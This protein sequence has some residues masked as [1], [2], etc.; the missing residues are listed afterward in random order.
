MKITFRATFSHPVH[1]LA[2]NL[3]GVT[4]SCPTR[5]EVYCA[6][7]TNGMGGHRW[8]VREANTDKRHQIPEAGEYPSAEAAKAGVSALFE[9][10]ID[11]WQMFNK[12][13]GMPISAEDL[14]YIAENGY[15]EPRPTLHL[16]AANEPDLSER[17]AKA[18]CG[19]RVLQTN[20]VRQN[21]TCVQCQ[22]CEERQAKGPRLVARA[23]K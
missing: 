5:I 9:R 23:N 15:A 14:R 4:V 13:T 8:N 17:T 1:G 7:S 12:C 6:S 19:K 10:Q 2:L 21:P 22:I 3:M 16:A 18:Q 20:I 11:P